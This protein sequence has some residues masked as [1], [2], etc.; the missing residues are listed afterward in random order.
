MSPELPS[1][2][3]IFEP[4]EGGVLYRL[5]RRP[6]PVM[7]L[8][9]LVPLLFGAFILSWPLLGAA[10]FLAVGGMQGDALW[11][12][13]LPLGCF[14]PIC[15]P[16]GGF[17]LGI[18]LFTLF[19]H[20]EVSVREGRLTSV[21]RCGWLRWGGN[22]PLEQIT[23]FHVA[24]TDPRPSPTGQVPAWV[25]DVGR[26]HAA[27]GDGQTFTVCSGY[28]RAGCGRL[29]DGWPAT[30]SVRH[31][32]P[33]QRRHPGEGDEE[34]LDPERIEGTPRSAARQHGPRGGERV[35][36]RSP[37]RRRDCGCNGFGVVWTVMWN[38]MLAIIAALP[39]GDR[40]RGNEVAGWPRAVSL[41][42]MCLFCRPSS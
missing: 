4:P 2:I 36:S 31:R 10:F 21:N 13:L 42:F 27:L 17:L 3:E 15:I 30:A 22:R 41:P 1:E 34:N 26:L 18:G 25:G 39:V 9:G 28:P 14:G 20:T 19:G 7:R 8:V 16:L 11:A 12:I 37:S 40:D 33:A 23:G 35:D 29:G 32:R 5:P 38:G 6:S 24:H